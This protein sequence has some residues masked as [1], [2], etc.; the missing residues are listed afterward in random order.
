MINIR[1]VGPRSPGTGP[2]AAG[3]EAAVVGGAL[4]EGAAVAD[5]AGGDVDGPAA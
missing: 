4:E 3:A 5:A 2:M 1:P